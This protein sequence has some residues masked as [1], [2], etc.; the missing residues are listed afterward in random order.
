MKKERVLFIIRICLWVIA[1]TSTF[2][3]M[4]YS[5][6][7][8]R[9]GIYEPYEYATLFRPVFYTCLVISVIAVCISF[10]LYAV[11]KGKIGKQG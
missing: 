4:S 10:I 3:W 5:I 6:R 2:Y 7:L 8:H 9:E 11:S 1:L